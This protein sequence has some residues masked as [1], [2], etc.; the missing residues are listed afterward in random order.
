MIPACSLVCGRP[1]IPEPGCAA[2][3]GSKGMGEGGEEK[4]REEGTGERK[5]Q[6]EHGCEPV[7]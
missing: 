3:S 4:K 6:G 1:K 7:R 5:I 2:A